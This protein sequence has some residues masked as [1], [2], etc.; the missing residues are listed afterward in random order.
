MRRAQAV[1]VLSAAAALAGC[2]A[3]PRQQVKDKVQQLARAVAGRNYETICANVLAPSLV[4]HLSA[5]GIGC[6][7]ATRMAFDEVEQ[8]TLSIGKVTV[9]GKHASVITLT[10]A[11]GQQAALATVELIETKSGWRISSLAGPAGTTG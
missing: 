10:V 7:Q 11:R 9:D 4:A 1:L 3:N 6:E 2:G 5:N 8:P